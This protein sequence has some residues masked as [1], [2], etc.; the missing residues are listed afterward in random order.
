M[1]NFSYIDNLEVFRKEL[2]ENVDVG[3]VLP[4]LATVKVLTGIDILNID[5]IAVRKEKRR[6]LLDTIIDKNTLKAYEEFLN[7]LQKSQC[8][9][10]FDLIRRGRYDAGVHVHNR[11]LCVL[12][13]C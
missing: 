1:A 3:K 11:G 6:K 12:F 5:I 13:N 2:L 4:H 8:F 7:A 10:A 9:V